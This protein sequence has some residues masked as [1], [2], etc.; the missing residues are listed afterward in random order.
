MAK[1]V[2]DKEGVIS[3]LLN[4]T[5]FASLNAAIDEYYLSAFSPEIIQALSFVQESKLAAELLHK[6]A[7]LK[8]EDKRRP[9]EF[10]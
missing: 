10:E 2:Q 5:K 8:T 9:P 7:A 4:Y 6:H 3:K 1:Q